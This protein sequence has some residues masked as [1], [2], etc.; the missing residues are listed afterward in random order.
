MERVQQ[1]QYQRVQQEVLVR[2]GAFKDVVVNLP[3]SLNLLEAKR[4]LIFVSKVVGYTIHT[5]DSKHSGSIQDYISTKEES[6]VPK[7]EKQFAIF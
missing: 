6:K 3:K 7:T 1:G 4:Y 2:E 5:I